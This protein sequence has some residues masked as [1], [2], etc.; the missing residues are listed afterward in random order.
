M[1]LRAGAHGDLPSLQGAGAEGP[2]DGVRAR[3]SRWHREHQKHSP[4]KAQDAVLVRYPAPNTKSTS[5]PE[6]AQT[7]PKKGHSP[8]QP[9]C[10]L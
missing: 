7:D 2:G 6:K 5:N 3:P 9:A 4:E 1:A 10:T 8:G